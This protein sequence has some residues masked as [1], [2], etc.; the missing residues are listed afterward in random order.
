MPRGG[1]GKRGAKSR[2][3][4]YHL[5]STGFASEV[6][7]SA[8]HPER[9]PS[10]PGSAEQELFE[11]L[12]RAQ[13]RCEDLQRQHE[14]LLADPGVIQEDRD[15]SAQLL[16]SAR[17]ALS[18]AQAAVAKLEEGTYGRCEVCGDPIPADRLEA[19]PE[20][21]RCVSCSS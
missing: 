17:S 5:G 7:M 14:E 15:A 4:G 12:S 11:E 6:S 10:E 13:A 20:A 21:T 9:G 18:V 16:A 8:S 19:V 1:R 2:S 3:T